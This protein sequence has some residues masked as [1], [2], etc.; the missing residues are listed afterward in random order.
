[1]V[2][3]IETDL[4]LP[5]VRVGRAGRGQF[6]FPFQGG[7]D[8]IHGN[9]VVGQFVPIYLHGDF[10]VPAAGKFHI[11]HAVGLGEIIDKAVVRQGVHFIQGMG[12]HQRQIQ[13]RRRVH[14]PLFHHRIIR[15]VRKALPD[16]IHLLGRIH[17]RRV[18]IGIKIQ[19]QCHLGPPGS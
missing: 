9:A 7:N 4:G 17:R 14:I 10:P 18:H 1:M 8:V 19:F 2:L 16:G 13:D 12:G 5:P 6:V 15:I 11:R 3:G